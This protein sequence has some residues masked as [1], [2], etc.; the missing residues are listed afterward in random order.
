LERTPVKAII[1]R[2]LNIQIPI[3]GLTGNMCL[4]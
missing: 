2:I 3:I 4:S 1:Q